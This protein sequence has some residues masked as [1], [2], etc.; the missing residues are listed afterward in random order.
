[1]YILSELWLFLNCSLKL[2]ILVGEQ[3]FEDSLLDLLIIFFLEE[4]IIEECN[5]PHHKELAA[6]WTH[7]ES[8]DRPVSWVTDRA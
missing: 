6:L 3:P 4:L 7:V 2:G 8:S 1:M 5:R